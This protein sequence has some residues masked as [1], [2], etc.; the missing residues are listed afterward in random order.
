MD[1]IDGNVKDYILK[2]LDPAMALF[3]SN[4]R[5]S[6]ANVDDSVFEGDSYYSQE[7]LRLGLIDGVGSFAEVANKL[8]VEVENR[9]ISIQ[10]SNL[11]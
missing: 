9:N 3:E 8:L 1:A 2:V 7:A 5:S 4:V 10:L 11:L 6:R